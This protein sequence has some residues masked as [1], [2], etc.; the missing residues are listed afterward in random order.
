MRGTPG[1]KNF[2]IHLYRWAAQELEEL[3]W[4]KPSTNQQQKKHTQNKTN[5]KKLVEKFTRQMN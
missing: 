1:H 4:L 5:K 2:H 3:L